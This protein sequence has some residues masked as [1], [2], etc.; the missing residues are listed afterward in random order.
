[1]NV[2]NSGFCPFVVLGVSHNGI[3]PKLLGLLLK[4]MLKQMILRYPHFEKPPIRY[5]CSCVFY[6]KSGSHLCGADY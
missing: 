3:T 4:M 2:L 1:M 5:P 6:E